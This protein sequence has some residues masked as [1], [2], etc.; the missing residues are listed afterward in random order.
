[1]RFF[2]DEDFN[3]VWTLEQLEGPYD[4]SE[5]RRAREMRPFYDTVDLMLDIHSMG[6]RSPALMICNGLEK[7]RIFTRKMNF[8]AHYLWVWACGGSTLIGIP[9]VSRSGQR[10]SS[11]LGGVRSALGQTRPALRLWIRLVTFWSQQVL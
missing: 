3:R 11:P 1:M 4:S 2:V 9:T 10:K 8:P 5:L 6:T 7:E